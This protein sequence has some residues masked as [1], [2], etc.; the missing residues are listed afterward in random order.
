MV[1]NF[2]LM[3]LG[4]YALIWGMIGIGGGWMMRR[5]ATATSPSFEQWEAPTADQRL[6]VSAA[7]S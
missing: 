4:N 2:R 6:P 3:A 7:A 1:W 5:L